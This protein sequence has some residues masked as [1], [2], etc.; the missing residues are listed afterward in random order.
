MSRTI[1]DYD[2][3]DSEEMYQTSVKGINNISMNSNIL[4]NAGNSIFYNKDIFLEYKIQKAEAGYKKVASSALV[5]K[6]LTKKEYTDE[7]KK[8]ESLYTILDKSLNKNPETNNDDIKTINDTWTLYKQIEEK[9]PEGGLINTESLKCF[10]VLQKYINKNTLNNVKD[11]EAIQEIGKVFNILKQNDSV[12]ITNTIKFFKDIK[13]ILDEEIIENFLSLVKKYSNVSLLNGEIAKIITNTEDTIDEQYIKTVFKITEV[14]NNQA[15]TVINAQKLYKQIEEKLPEGGLIITENLKCFKVLNSCENWLNISNKE[16]I[17]ISDAF[18]FSKEEVQTFLNS[19]SEIEGIKVIISNLIDLTKKSSSILNDKIT[20]H[21][22]SE[23]QTLDFDFALDILCN[24]HLYDLSSKLSDFDSIVSKK[25]KELPFFNTSVNEEINAQEFLASSLTYQKFLKT[26]TKFT[27]LRTHGDEIDTNV[28]YGEALYQNKSYSKTIS[29]KSTLSKG[30]KRTEE[31]SALGNYCNISKM[32]LQAQQKLELTDQELIKT[33]QD[34]L[35]GQNLYN[36][37]KPTPDVVKTLYDITYLLFSCEANRNPEALIS[38]AIFLELVEQGKYTINQ[39]AYHLPMAMSGAIEIGRFFH[40]HDKLKRVND[41][42]KT[43]KA[44]DNTNEFI[45][46]ESVLLQ[47]WVGLEE[48]AGEASLKLI[49]ENKVLDKEKKK[50]KNKE[51]KGE[52]Q[53]EIDKNKEQI[54]EIADRCKELFKNVS[55]E[56]IQKLNE[57][58]QRWYGVAIKF[59][60]G[61]SRADG[62]DPYDDEL[63]DPTETVSSANKYCFVVVK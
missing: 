21:V 38:N 41:Y 56:N 12:H 25:I 31:V 29:T 7:D 13:S 52:I 22:T 62:F 14:C 47:K 30:L 2:S 45:I 61:A 1:F 17:N 9:L 28:Q 5:N 19:I 26:I 43:I 55:T 16:Q 6:F 39:M 54:Q 27:L 50:E 4:Y 51:A 37:H 46:K 34:I 44:P 33:F 35:K 32:L 11:K 10:G 48:I 18:N 49:E 58:I 15:Q 57:L 42:A 40:N 60:A 59:K 23:R 53:Q 8:P 63:I 36:R 24:E 20:N 3:S